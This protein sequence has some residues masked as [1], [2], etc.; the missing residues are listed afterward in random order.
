MSIS[1]LSFYFILRIGCE[2]VG[3]LRSALGVQKALCDVRVA[4]ERGIQVKLRD[5]ATTM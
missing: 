1:H 2:W 4:M 3:N 5:D